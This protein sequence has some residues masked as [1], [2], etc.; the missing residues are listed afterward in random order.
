MRFCFLSTGCWRNNGT[1]PRSH[2]LGA[3]LARAGVDVVFVADRTPYNEL[4]AQ[5][6]GGRV[7]FNDVK[8]GIGQFRARAERVRE[9]RADFVH[10]MP[11]VKTYLTLRRLPHTRIVGDWDEWPARRPYNR[12]LRRKVF[13]F[14]DS[15]LR[16]RSALRVV[17]SKYM[18]D[19]FAELFG[20]SALYLP[21]AGFSP[22]YDDGHNPYR[23]PTA[24]YMGTLFPAF[25]HAVVFEAADI[26]KRRGM[27]HAIRVIGDGPESEHWTDFIKERS[28][29][30]EM[31]GN[32]YGDELWRAV[33]HAHVLLFPIRD[34]LVNA[35]RCPGKLFYYLQ[36][37][38]PIIATYVG[39][40][41]SFL[42]DRHR[43]V[44]CDA[45][46][47]ADA[48][49][50]AMSEPRAPDIKTDVGTWDDRA[51]TLIKELCS[52]DK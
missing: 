7:I 2:L 20:Q 43:N 33:R 10:A 15:W 18:R 46:A 49:S 25:D 23:R 50:K 31:T 16:D 13:S 38:R 4:E 29:N 39:E 17:A 44:A 30:V 22:E 48:I 51:Q 11:A 52:L 9:A 26:L 35:C 34:S 32:L 45:T 40:V 36:A 1:I 6:L 3:A 12:F 41:A 24:V 28:L 8:Q 21:H 42:D 5:K 19:K 37:S 14:V 47:F 27:N